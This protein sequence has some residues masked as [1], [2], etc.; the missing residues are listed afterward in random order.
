[1]P[2]RYKEK[3]P[4]SLAGR[5]LLTPVLFQVPRRGSGNI[6]T[7]PEKSMNLA[8]RSVGHLET[9]GRR[10]KTAKGV[11]DSRNGQSETR[12]PTR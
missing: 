6:T 4:G 11:L 3:E 1:M 7:F 12:M 9:L 5:A 8:R 10:V 2:S